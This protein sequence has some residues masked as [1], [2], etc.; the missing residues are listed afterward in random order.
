MAMRGYC[1]PAECKCDDRFTCRVCLSRSSS[2]RGH[3][4]EGAD[5][6]Y[7]REMTAKAEADNLDSSHLTEQ[8]D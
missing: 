1:K 8:I 7:R 2:P 5:A 6:R 3:I 4:G